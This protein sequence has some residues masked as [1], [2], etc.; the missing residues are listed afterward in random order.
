MQLHFGLRIPLYFG[1]DLQA[2]FTRVTLFS[3]RTTSEAGSFLRIS[4]RSPFIG[5]LHTS[6]RHAGLT[7]SPR[8][9]KLLGFLR[10]T[11]NHGQYRV[12]LPDRKST[13]LNSSHLGI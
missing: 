7:V 10:S 5:H 9:S 6:V 4:I 12:D 2:F 13:R 3:Q 8:A 1:N 11:L